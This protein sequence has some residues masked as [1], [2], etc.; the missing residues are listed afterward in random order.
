MQTNKPKVQLYVKRDFGQKFEATLRFIRENYRTL[1]KYFTYF[2]LPVCLVQGLTLDNVFSRAFT[3]GAN[4]ASTGNEITGLLNNYI[5]LMVYYIGYALITAIG[6]L[7]LFPVL[8]GMKQ[9]Y[10][11]RENRLQG[12]TWADLR[13]F[14][15]QNLRRMLRLMLAGLVI[16][17]VAT[18]LWVG[19]SILLVYISPLLIG[20]VVLL[21]IAF[22]LLFVPLVL[23]APIYLFEP[24]GVFEALKKAMK[25]G[26]KRWGSIL[27]FV[28][29][30]NMVTSILQGITTMP[31]YIAAIVKM[32]FNISHADD[33]SFINSPVFSFFTYLLA[34]VQT[35]GL[36]LS[37]AI[38]MV[39]TFYLYGDVIETAE[40]RSVDADIDK[41]ET[42]G[43][44]HQDD[45]MPIPEDIKDFDK[46]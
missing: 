29:V 17:G 18:I 42:L 21:M 44:D 41:F 8:F 32:F 30:L 43:D 27:V 11:E 45:P 19:I 16:G 37:I 9:L 3:M 2:I 39:G 10:L 7:L 24:I 5:G 20:I 25:L 13:P 1:L 15:M 22:L 38:L 33:G 6:T 4:S 35:Y 26:M 46:L 14:F 28:F 31:W 12:I 40:N 36:Y 34:I 23:W